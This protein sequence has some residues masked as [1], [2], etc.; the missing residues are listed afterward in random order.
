[1]K[2]IIH[3]LVIVFVLF[4]FLSLGSVAYDELTQIKGVNTM[5]DPQPVTSPQPVTNG[6]PTEF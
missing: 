2:Q 1:M 5:N 4:L 3:P 6:E